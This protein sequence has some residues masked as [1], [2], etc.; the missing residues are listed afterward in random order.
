M[1]DLITVKATPAPIVVSESFKILMTAGLAVAADRC[2]HS[3]TAVVAVV[4]CGGIIATWVW[5]LR[6]R[7]KTWGALK[8]LAGFVPDETAVVK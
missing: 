7:L 8:F 3:E 2:L 5:G 6:H 4:A 1:S